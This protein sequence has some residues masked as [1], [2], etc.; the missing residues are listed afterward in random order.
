MAQKGIVYHS[1][2]KNSTKQS[3]L[4]HQ[5]DDLHDSWGTNVVRPNTS[6][7][8]KNNIF[9]HNYAH[10]NVTRRSDKYF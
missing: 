9:I 4:I 7:E 1:T 3:P 6:M 5:D 10:V 2:F 8:A